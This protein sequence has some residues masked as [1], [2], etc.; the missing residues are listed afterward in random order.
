MDSGDETME[1]YFQ[2]KSGVIWAI[3]TLLLFFYIFGAI[4]GELIAAFIVVIAIGIIIWIA[5][6]NRKQVSNS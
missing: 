6:I 5:T 3:L 2:K 1:R 4:L